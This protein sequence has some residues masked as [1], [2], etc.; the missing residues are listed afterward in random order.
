MVAATIPVRSADCDCAGRVLDQSRS[1]PEIG[2]TGMVNRWQVD[3]VRT[4]AWAAASIWSAASS[5]AH[6]RA[7]SKLSHWRP[8][9]M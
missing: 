2:S 7:A 8:T 4:A 3:S 6:E 1:D 5:S 9:R